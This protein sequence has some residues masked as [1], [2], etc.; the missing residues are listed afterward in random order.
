V[1]TA[2]SAGTARRGA[3]ARPTVSTAST[4]LYVRIVAGV[5]FANMASA[6]LYVRIVAGLVFANTASKKLDVRNA[7]GASYVKHRIVKPMS[8][9]INTKDTV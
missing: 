1:S 8:I 5:V 9:A 3:A 7:V 2:S 4:K 6:K